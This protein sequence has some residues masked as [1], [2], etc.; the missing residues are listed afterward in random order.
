MTASKNN[1]KDSS[2]SCLCLYS[3]QEST[4][5]LKQISTENFWSV[6]FVYITFVH[7][8]DILLVY[9]LIDILLTLFNPYLLSHS[10]EHIMYMSPLLK[11][12]INSE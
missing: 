3:I 7:Q 2:L 8:S 10:T 9:L 4:P 6:L 1:L 12:L 11:Y 5:D